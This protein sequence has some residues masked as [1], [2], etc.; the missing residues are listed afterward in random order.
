MPTKTIALISLLAVPLAVMAAMTREEI[1]ARAEV[2]EVWQ[3]E[4]VVVAPSGWA[5]GPPADALVLF[6]GTDLSAWRSVDGGPAN[7]SVDNGFVEV[8]PGSGDIETL[9]VFADV[10]LHIE[11]ATPVAVSGEGQGRGN[12]GVFLMGR[13]EVQILDSHANRT[14]S[15]GQA[16]SVYKQH[17]PLVNASRGP[18]QWQTY[19][20][21]FM[22]PRFNATGR[23]MRPAEITVLHNGVVVQNRVSIQG[24]TQF[25]GKPQYEAHGAAPIKLQD[26]ANPVR[27]RNMWVRRL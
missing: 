5:G 13:Y 20:I 10:Q 22:A 17:I 2:T 26:H 1:L 19:D 21:I 14:Y 27:F 9:E 24:P 12:S 15:N 11:W 23:V 25:V 4:P 16:A 18:G 7:W 6:D 3:P 8:K